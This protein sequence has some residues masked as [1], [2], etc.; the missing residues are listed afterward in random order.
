[1]TTTIDRE[2]LVTVLLQQSK[3]L[4]LQYFQLEDMGISMIPLENALSALEV[5]ILSAYGLNNECCYE[6]MQIIYGYY[7]DQVTLSELLGKLY[8]A[9]NNSGASL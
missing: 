1:M 5:C 3:A 8:L 6:A 4:H 7:T 9:A 2:P